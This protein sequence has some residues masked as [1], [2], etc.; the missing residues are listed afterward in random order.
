M[1]CPDGDR[2]CINCYKS[3]WMPSDPVS[4]L[5]FVTA[6]FKLKLLFF[7]SFL[8][9]FP[10]SFQMSCSKNLCMASKGVKVTSNE[11]AQLDAIFIQ[12]QQP[13]TEGGKSWSDPVCPGPKT[14]GPVLSPL[15]SLT[16][17][18]SWTA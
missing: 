17:V 11:W 5:H 16:S 12:V 6:H 18:R 7:F 14:F 1:M 13:A 2:F 3:L 10:F 4:T 9:F 8:S 15:I